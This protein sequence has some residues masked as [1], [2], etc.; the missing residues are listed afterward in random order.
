VLGIA[1]LSF[2][3][4]LILAV[5]V[6]VVWLHTGTGRETLGRYV[7][8][9]AR[10]AIQGNLRLHDIVVSGFLRVCADGAELRDPEGHLALR[11]RRVCVQLQPL[12]LQAHRIVIG[13]A[14]LDQPWVE[15]AKVPG[16]SETTL[17]RAIKPK[18]PPKPKQEGGGPFEWKIEV[19]S[20]QIRGGSVTVR[21]ELGEEATFALQD[22][23]L[24]QAHASYSADAA[25]AAL[26]VS[27]QLSAPGKAAAAL[28]LDATVDGPAATGN[29][30]L[31]SLRVKV[32]ESGLAASGSWDLSRNTGE[33]RLREMMVTPKDL[34][35]F[36]PRAPLEGTVRGEIDA[37]TDGK[38]AGADLRLEAGGGRIQAK[39]TS[40]IEK[41]P[42]WDVQL[43]LD[44][45]D[46][47][48]I[49][50]RAPKGEITATVSLHGKGLPQLDP[51]GVRGEL[52]AAV[53]VGP[54]RLDRVGPVV[55]DFKT[56]LQGRYAIVHAFTATAL[57]LT[58][59]AHGAAAYDELSMDLDIRAPDLAE[60]GRAVG[61]LTRKPSLPMGGSMR[62]IAR[63]T[64]SPRKPDARL[65]IK[66]PELRYSKSLV[67]DGLE[68]SGTLAGSLKKPNGSLKVAAKR[69]LASAVDLGAPHIDVDLQWPIAHL[70]IDAAVAGGVLQLAGDARIDNDKDGLLLSNFVVAWPGNMLRLAGETRVHF[71]DEVILEPLELKGDHGSLR[72]QAQVQPPPGR[73]DASLVVVKFDLDHL[74]Q[75]VM[76]KDLALHGEIDAN[77]VVQGPRD[78]PEID[79]QADVRGAGAR[80]AGDLAA[81]AHAHAHLHRGVLKTE[82]WVASTGML[83][84]DF[85]GE[86]PAQGL[87]KLPAS[88]PVRFEAHFAK[89]DL[90]KLAEAA[91]LAPLQRNRVHGI[92]DARFVASGTLGAPQATLAVEA[93]DLGTEKLQQLDARAGVLLDKMRATVDA[94]VSLAGQPVVSL[95]AQAPLDLSRALRD[96]AYL[97]AALERPVSGELA[98]TQ[99][100]LARLAKSGLVPA[101]SEGTFNLSVKLTGTPLKPGVHL[102]AA[103]EKITLGRL[104]G[105]DFQSELSVADKVRFSFG[106]QSEATAVAR[107]QAGASLSGGEIVEL[108]ARRGDRNALL[109]L[110]DRPVSL[111]LEV[112]GLPIARASQLTGKGSVAQGRL[113]GRLTLAGSPARP[114]L[115]GQFTLKDLEAREKKLGGADFYVEADSDGALV[116]LAVDPPGGG[117]L[118]GHLNLKAD[119]G[120]RSLLSGG[121]AEVMDGK[122]S[123]EVK[124]NR[125]DLGFLSGVV[126]NLRRATGTLQG[127]VKLAGALRKP[128]GQGEA[129][130]RGGLFD[131]VGQGV[132]EDVGF[133]ANFSPKEVVVDRVTGTVGA[134][135]FSAILV[136]ARRPPADDPTSDRIEFTGE[137]HLGDGESV[138]DRK[139]PG[140]D[141]AL[142]AG[143]LP[144]RQAGEQR[145]DVTGELDVFGDYTSGALTLNAKIPDARMVI[146]QLPSKKLPSLKENPDVILVHPGERP[147]PPGREPGEVEAE[148]EARKTATF[149][150]HAKLDL[151]H[152]YV[153]APDFEFPVESHM[154]FEYNSRQPGAP[155]ADGVIHVPQGSFNALGRRFT[156]DDAKIIETGGDIA[157]P[158]LEIK[159]LY[160]NPQAAVT[161]TV[162]GTART[163]QLDLSSN[164]A[165]D[166]DQIAFFLATGRIQGRATQQGGGVDLSGAATSVVGSLLFG[167]VRKEMADVLPVDVITIDSGPQG[168]SGASVGKYIGDKVFVGYRQRFTTQATQ[169]ENSAEGRIEYEI[170]RSLAAEAVVGDYSQELSIFWTKDF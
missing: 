120:A 141:Q 135:T 34:A 30:T 154:N 138:R 22:L 86:V 119:L 153:T 25:A 123:G 124:A 49:S 165:M 8:N 121:I 32:G 104:H 73:I 18:K 39:L 149:R 150:L 53:H 92:V 94:T 129:H 131:V 58:V 38:T 170:N 74:P 23:D 57:G 66:A 35:L 112:P 96:R 33:V 130:L 105:L 168:V 24:G 14:Q 145:A 161:I 117:N 89:V 65:Q 43:S 44:R 151:D 51:H 152:L 77:A 162:T 55:A 76:P 36:A 41:P 69:V 99:L 144:V 67:V 118:L 15:I 160:D 125:L 3:G 16:T 110:L 103:G 109:P 46:P 68:V 5:G 9:E 71:R 79:L 48:A 7:A 45:V 40:T 78:A 157:D 102:N 54:A 98:V 70:G 159:A 107:L 4:F 81:D 146:K 19:R 126:P 85:Q 156:I 147:H 20:L 143:P 127:D 62:V 137:V 60:V 90:A 169:T 72:L 88:T 164:Q 31:R 47:G 83:R 133:D 155:T 142:K 122:V 13:E 28:T 6:A 52:A 128:V 11:A 132:Y 116:H 12:A 87:A 139:T 50:D 42:V 163:P 113:D 80:P 17:A 166:Q 106:A 64:G 59:S 111:T 148:E 93:R 134:G 114:Q 136:A 29:V 37:K 108:A 82:G 56:D 158:E 1:G 100:P 75:F 10:N 27:A 26:S 95:T 21:P 167:Q 97:R 2:L 115:K 101:G 140:T 61:A 84:L 63:V 91:K